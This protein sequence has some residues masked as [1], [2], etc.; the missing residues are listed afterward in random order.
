MRKDRQVA[1]IHYNTPELTEAAI[2]AAEARRGGLSCDGVRQLGTGHR[3]EDG[4][5]VRGTAIHG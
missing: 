3:P 5:A 4:R 1:I 2:V